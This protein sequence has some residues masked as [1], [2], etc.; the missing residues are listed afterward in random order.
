MSGFSGFAFA[1]IAGAILAHVYPPMTA[2]P[3]LMICGFINQIVSAVH[4]RASINWRGSVPL[5]IG[6]AVGLP[7]GVLLLLHADAAC[8]R[9]GF[10]AFL[11]CYATFM[12]FCP[13]LSALRAWSG[14]R[15]AMLVGLGGGVVG[16]L[17]AMPG[18]LPTVWFDL[19]GRT[20]QEKRGLLQ[21]FIM[22]MQAL[23]LPS[24]SWCGM[25]LSM[26]YSSQWRCRPWRRGRCWV[27]R[28]MGGSMTGVP[29][30]GPGVVVV[31]RRNAGHKLEHFPD[32]SS[33]PTFRSSP[34][35]RSMRQ[36]QWKLLE[37][38]P[39]K[40]VAVFGKDHA[41]PKT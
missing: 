26:A 13:H 3:L 12:V 11:F 37:H 29:M 25:T 22:R 35:E 15:C 1:A 19:Q 27:R 2:I 21:P 41:P 24:S 30:R 16:G 20:R 10:G 32:R 33:Q 6:G 38:D 7:V 4:L 17:T 28:S 39:E 14:D 34:H 31:L 9:I 5:A 18:A 40:C 36:R 8:F 23:S